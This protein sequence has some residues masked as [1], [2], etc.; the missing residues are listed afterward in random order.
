MVS[1]G[2]KPWKLS[3]VA[4]LSCCTQNFKIPFLLFWGTPE[5]QFPQRW[6]MWCQWWNISAW[7]EHYLKA[8]QL[9]GN[10]FCIFFICSFWLL[11]V[12]IF[13][14]TV[15]LFVVKHCPPFEA[16]LCREN[17]HRTHFWWHTSVVWSTEQRRACWIVEGEGNDVLRQLKS[18]S[19]SKSSLSGSV[20]SDLRTWP[21]TLKHNF[22]VPDAWKLQAAFFCLV[23]TFVVDFLVF[24]DLMATDGASSTGGLGGHHITEKLVKIVFFL[25]NCP[26]N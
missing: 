21:Q 16:K 1:L 13:D 10:S 6:V 7:Q 15:S 14:K 26:A 11:P 19:A 24:L 20:S 17:L 5:L 9:W 3:T 4:W 18:F 2:N 22:Q 12:K 25:R 8:L 23:L